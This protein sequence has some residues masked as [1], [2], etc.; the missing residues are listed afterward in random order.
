M[1]TEEQEYIWSCNTNG[2]DADE[3]Q[4]DETISNKISFRR[5]K[6]II[7]NTERAMSGTVGNFRERNSEDV[8]WQNS[9]LYWVDVGGNCNIVGRLNRHNERR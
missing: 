1:R 7:A 5:A 6:E 8:G 3:N 9:L 4:K 2:L